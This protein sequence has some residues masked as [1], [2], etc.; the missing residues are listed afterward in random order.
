MF[1]R[2]PSRDVF[3][4]GSFPGYVSR[5]IF[6]RRIQ[7][8]FRDVPQARFSVTFAG[9]VFGDVSGHVVFGSASRDGLRSRVSCTVSGT[10]SIYVFQETFCQSRFCGRALR[11][12]QIR[13]HMPFPEPHPQGHFPGTFSGMML[14]TTAFHMLHTN[15]SAMP[16]R[17]CTILH[18]S[19]SVGEVSMGE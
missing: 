18:T 10:F 5:D 1:S 13:L 14:H 4:P 6:Q 16:V 2:V 11:R 17:Y 8:H 7:I 12:S 15:F 3:G 19:T 9:G